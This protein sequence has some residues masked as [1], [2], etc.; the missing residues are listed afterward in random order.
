[1]TIPAVR[2]FGRSRFDHLPVDALRARGL[3][4][5][6]GGEGPAGVGV[7]LG[8]ESLKPAWRWSRGAGVPLALFIWDIPPWRLASG[9]PY[10]VV[11]LFGRLL[12]IPRPW[13]RITR[14]PG[15]VS[16]VLYAGARAAAFWV[17]SGYSADC[18]RPYVGREPTRVPYCYDAGRFVPAAV[19]RDPDVVL[20]VSRL[21]SYKGQ[22]DLIR[23]VALMT[24]PPRVRL[25]G[26][27][28][29]GE[30]LRGLAA[31]LGVRCSIESAVDDAGVVEAYRTAGVVACPSHFEGFGLTGLEAL[32]CRAPVVASDI[33]PHREFLGSGVRYFPAGDVAALAVRLEDARSAA[34]LPPADLTEL[35]PAAAAARIHAALGP[36]LGDRGVIS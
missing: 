7:C 30:E 3:D 6:L 14:R 8:G 29:K 32:G 27:G 35:T 34:P 20:A 26:R 15:T 4:V 5:A 9:R 12:A 24:R 16:R 10:P 2:W 28:E 23:A 17:P 25:I 36:F 13:A 18:L 21:I 11:D 1:M 22:S 19:E 33:P 31:T